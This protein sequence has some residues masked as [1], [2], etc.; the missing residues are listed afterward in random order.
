MFDDFEH[1]CLNQKVPAGICRLF[2]VNKC[3]GGEEAS[4]FGNALRGGGQVQF[5]LE[6]HSVQGVRAGGVSP[7]SR[8]G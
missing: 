1:F 4:F 2:K 6:M 8:E 7:P 5:E 3:T